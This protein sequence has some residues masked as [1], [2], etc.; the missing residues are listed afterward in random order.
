[1]LSHNELTEGISLTW[2]AVVAV[3]VVTD[4]GAICRENSTDVLT[5][6]NTRSRFSDLMMEIMFPS[7]PAIYILKA[8]PSSTGRRIDD[9]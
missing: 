2:G 3:V 7:S 9:K 1:M 5:K 8:Q 6:M 4:I